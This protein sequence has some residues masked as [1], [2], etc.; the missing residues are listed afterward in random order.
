VRTGEKEMAK[1]SARGRTELFRMEKVSA[2]GTPEGLWRILAFMS[3]GAVLR[4][5]KFQHLYFDGT[6]KVNSTTWKVWK[7][8]PKIGEAQKLFFKDVVQT[9]EKQEYRRI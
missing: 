2:W 1:L 9:L 7:K 6:L 3:D 8:G 5:G 4:K